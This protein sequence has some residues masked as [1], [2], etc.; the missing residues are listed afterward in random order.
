MGDIC[1]VW[2]IC[3]CLVTIIVNSAYIHGIKVTEANIPATRKNYK[4]IYGTELIDP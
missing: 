3:Y 1:I 4:H 2:I